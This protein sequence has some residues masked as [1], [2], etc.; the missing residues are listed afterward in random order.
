[1]TLAELKERLLLVGARWRVRSIINDADAVSL[2]NTTYPGVEISMQ[3]YSLVNDCSPYCV[4]CHTP[5]KTYGKLTCS[6]ACREKY[7]KDNGAVAARLEKARQTC[8]D[9]Y[10]VDNPLKSSNIRDKRSATMIEKYGSAVSDKH[11]ESARSRVADLITRGRATLLEKYG[12]ENPGQLK[13]HAGKIQQTYMKKHGVSHYKL[14][15]EYQLRVET[16][17]IKRYGLFS[18]SDITVDNTVDDYQKTDI[19]QNPNRVIEFS[20]KTCGTSGQRLPS[21]TYKWRIRNAGSP[22]NKCSHISHGSLKEAEVADY[23][24][25]LGVQVITNY[26]ILD[27]KEIDIFLPEFNLGIE[28]HGLFW[29][30]DTRLNKNYH[31][32]K[33]RLAKEKGIRLI[34]IFEDEWQHRK[35]IVQSRLR[36][37]VGKSTRIY[38]RKCQIVE[39]NGKESAD[40]LEQNHIQG[41]AKSSIKLGLVHQGQLVAVMTF[42]RPNL[43]RGYKNVET[44]VWELM[45][46]ASLIGTTIVGGANRLYRYF[47]HTY[48][49]V[50]VI[51]YSDLRWNT[52]NIYQTLGFLHVGDTAPGYW[53]INLKD[54]RRI[55]RFSLRK[56]DQ[57][58]KDK[59]EYELRLQQGYL[60]IWDCGN[61]KWEWSR[62]PLV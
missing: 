52:G 13:D 41:Q 1:M 19:F 16:E 21:E 12:V 61:S 44:G 35:Q 55:H 54:T 18:P 27:G 33:Y 57:D 9:R 22:C 56:T 15:D 50:K 60:R 20:C 24:R 58:P 43:S 8:V 40:F 37:L 7:S 59:T 26:R 32:D 62:A 39:V 38:A 5:V 14:T 28:F 36:N 11:R 34:Q 46:F 49:P 48:Q 53:Y 51:S 2:L 47:L 17:R 45:R 4:V 10:G 3:V 30:N 25:S 6:V 23:I 42:S 31:L 29:H